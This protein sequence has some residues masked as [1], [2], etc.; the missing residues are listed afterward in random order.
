[1][2]DPSMTDPIHAGGCLCG[3]VR[4]RAAGAPDSTDLC[5]CT[6]CRRQTGSAMP[7]FATFAPDRVVLTRGEPVSYRS[8]DIA[9]RE[10]CGACGSPLFW[11]PDDGRC[12]DILLGAFDDPAA[13][14]APTFALWTRHRLPWL[15]PLPGVPDHD[16]RYEPEG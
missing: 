15:P 1:M 13:L 9:R 6:Q 10:F 4:F 14:P 2:T 3:A 12:V 7:A 11:R 5:Y 8:S 16:G